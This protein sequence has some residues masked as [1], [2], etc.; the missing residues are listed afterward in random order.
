M[1]KQGESM[2]AID[3]APARIN[4]DGVC[5]EQLWDL[6]TPLET[7]MFRP[8]H[9]QESSEK[10]EIFVTYDES[11]LY[12]AGRLH[13]SNKSSVIATT[14]KRDAGAFGNDYF[15]IM[16][17]TFNDNESALCFETSPTGL[18]SDF[19]IAND[20]QVIERQMPFNRSWNTF[21]DVE[22][23]MDGNVWH[24][25]MRIPF[26]SLRFQEQN[27]EVIMGM[28]IWRVIADKQEFAIYPLVTN[29]FGTL[30]I[31]KPSQA[32]KVVFKGV[33]RAIPLYITPYALVGVEQISEMTEDES[34]YERKTDYT[35]NAGLDLKYP[36]TSNMTLDLTFNTDFAQVEVDDQM[37]NLTRFS[38]FFPEKR[39][40]FLERASLFTVN[41]GY[42]DQLFYSRRIG[43]YEGEIIPIWAGARLVGRAGKWDVGIM[44]MQTGK[45]DYIDEDTDSLETILSTNH[46][47]Y[48]LRKQAFNPRSY[49]GGMITSQIDVEGNYNINTA[50]DGII[51]PFRDDYFSFNYVQTFDSDVDYEKDFFDHGK[52]YLNWEDRSNVGFNYNVILSRAGKYYNPEMGFEL[53][54]DYS[55][56]FMMLGYGWV[57]NEANKKLLD[58]QITSWIW[59][60]KQNQDFKTDIRKISAGYRFSTKKGFRGSVELID[61]Y[62]F[63]KDTFELSDDVYFPNGEYTYT[64]L[65]ASLGTPSNK[66]LSLRAMVEV[67]TYYDGT[68]INLG[69]AQV[70]FRPSSS[71]N[72]GLDYQYSLITTAPSRNQKFISHLVRLRTEL[73]FTT[74]L[75]I[76]AFFQ[77]SSNDKFGVNNIRFRYNPREGNDL[78]IVYNGEYNTHLNREIPNLPFSEISNL[79]VKYTYTFTVQSGRRKQKQHV[80]NYR[81]N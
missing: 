22:T 69:P 52:F 15:G 53:M 45:A 27:G 11:Y 49:L 41:T 51:N 12:L 75:S 7:K 29:N 76:S 70:F 31:W 8:N 16:L 56:A 20:A 43:L 35:L 38:L 68:L 55:R 47:V 44:N 18:R 1:G 62:E 39:Q 25:E 73:T 23:T 46:G 5:K 2:L 60:N 17:D 78:Y 81:H 74:K 26:S 13:Y 67:G 54:E 34:G 79:I 58:Q 37:V 6:V 40:F 21:W 64:N 42:M 65:S 9:G 28:T 19:A 72:L 36:I 61:S 30:G 59:V 71:V 10:S 66:M 48:R 3:R 4:F 63:L 32:Q 57:Y 50:L 80:I 24:V 77:Y 14:K 33:T